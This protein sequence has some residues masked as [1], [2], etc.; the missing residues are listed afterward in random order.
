MSPAEAWPGDRLQ[1][2]GGVGGV[3]GLL[4][5]QSWN[6]MEGVWRRAA[7]QAVS[8]LLTERSEVDGGPLGPL[9]T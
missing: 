9:S 5:I 4:Q 1:T 3:S 2:R 7:L 6:R 8:G